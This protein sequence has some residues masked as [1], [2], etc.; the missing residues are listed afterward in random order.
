MALYSFGANF[1]EFVDLSGGDIVVFEDDLE[2]R[3]G[4][5]ADLIN[6]ID[7][8]PNLTL[9]FKFPRQKKGDR[10]YFLDHLWYIAQT[11]NHDF[12]SVAIGP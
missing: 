11:A 1:A 3:T 5:D 7:F 9:Q 4:G 12:N 8:A 10:F 2:D 6:E